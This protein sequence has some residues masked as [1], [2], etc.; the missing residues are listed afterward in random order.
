MWS[1]CGELLIHIKCKSQKEQRRKITYV[2]FFVTRQ[3]IL[4]DISKQLHIAS[5]VLLHCLRKIRVKLLK[6]IEI[7]YQFHLLTVRQVYLKP[8]NSCNNNNSY[9]II[10]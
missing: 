1:S 9:N 8:E 4:N 3:Q 5:C 10:L 7:N 6:I 2:L